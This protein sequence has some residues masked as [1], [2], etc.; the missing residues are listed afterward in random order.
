MEICRLCA[1]LALAVALYPLASWS[2][3][4]SP[5]TPAK[6]FVRFGSRVVA[7]DRGGSSSVA[8]PSSATV[9]PSS[10]S[11]DHASLAVNVYNSS[12]YTNTE[13]I[14]TAVNDTLTSINSCY[15]YYHRPSNLLYLMNDAGTDWLPA[16]HPGDVG[17]YAENSR[18]RIDG[19]G[20]SFSGEGTSAKLTIKFTFNIAFAGSKNTYVSAGQ[21]SGSYGGWGT[22]GSWSVP[23]TA[24]I[25]LVM[26]VSPANGSG[27]AGTLK[28]STV[29]NDGLANIKWI[30]LIVNGT[31]SSSNACHIYYDQ[32]SN[33]IFLNNDSASSWVGSG[34]PGSGTILENGQCRIILSQSSRTSALTTTDLNV[35]IEFKPG[36]AGA[37]RLYATAGDF[38]EN[39]VYWADFGS[40]N[41]F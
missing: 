36:F 15:T 33:S 12:G 10:G 13:W 14:Q 29:K 26:S 38:A 37:K 30:Q 23:G 21:P 25:P 7:V 39:Y 3:G 22:V 40:W 1:S 18:C 6:E 27:S 4:L 9:S 19:G 31:L 2:Q 35:R 17:A 5:A 16:F 28:I 34:V 20:T 8:T 24:Q 11:T 41:A 32:S